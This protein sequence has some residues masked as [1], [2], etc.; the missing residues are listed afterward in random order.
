MI[1][2]ANAA[3]ADD[4]T[5]EVR[6]EPVTTEVRAEPGTI[7]KEARVEHVN[8]AVLDAARSRLRHLCA[9]FDP[10][11]PISVMARMS[12]VPFRALDLAV[13]IEIRACRSDPI[14]AINAPDPA[15]RTARAA[16]DVWPKR[17]MEKRAH[18]PSRHP[19]IS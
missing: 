12:V 4:A 11:T 9:R 16:R 13:R 15:H 7:A 5:I 19:L 8:E 6:V 10:S 1:A 14:A 17:S 18:V 2:R 3:R